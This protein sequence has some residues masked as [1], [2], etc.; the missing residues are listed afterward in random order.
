[1]NLLEFIQ[2]KTTNFIEWGE[3]QAGNSKAADRLRKAIEMYGHLYVLEQM[4]RRW[5]HL[6][7]QEAMARLKAEAGI[8]STGQAVDDKLWSYVNCFKCL[9]AQ[10]DE[11]CLASARPSPPQAD[12][13]S[14]SGSAS[15]PARPA[16]PPA[17]S[18]A[19]TP[20]S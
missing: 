8:S 3:Q 10:V 4:T 2:E 14:P 18:P 9:Q 16:S 7:R 20:S 1:M 12:A 15:S 17:G 6:E 19:R 13:A 5:A 11:A